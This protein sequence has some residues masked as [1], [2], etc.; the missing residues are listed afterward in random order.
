L[1]DAITAANTQTR[2]NGCKAGSGND[3]IQFSVSGTIMLTALA[4]TPPP[5]SAESLEGITDAQLTIKGPI[6]ISADFRIADGGGPILGVAST[7]TVKLQNLTIENGADSVLTAFRNEGTLT[8]ADS[9]IGPR[10]G[11]SINDGTL[12]V[13][14]STFS[15]NTSLEPTEPGAIYNTGTL[16][17]ANST[18]SGNGA[19]GPGTITNSGVL[20]ITDSTFS[21]N[22]SASIGAIG[23]VGTLAITNSTFSGNI[24]DF[25]AGA[26]YNF[27]T[28]T[29]ISSTFFGNGS[30]FQE[31]GFLPAG[32][33]EDA[34]G[35]VNIK[36]SILAGSFDP[37]SGTPGFLLTVSNCSG[38]AVNDDGYNISDDGSC[39][40]VKTG[41][42][43][44]GD[45][46]N[47]P[48]MV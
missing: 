24:G 17:I 34:G 8:I 32:A 18:F 45:N 38:A 28:L 11:D 1:R 39:G 29:V 25:D 2:V 33:I 6:A 23:N 4:G 9:T 3:T 22:G 26:I 42:A 7:A 44:N 43:N 31:S 13:T 14:N 30:E 40:F 47:Y 48:Q 15:G 12:V 16:T 27:G 10:N 37:N 35:V 36:N 46:V 21:D 19:S 41:T 5:G 20:T